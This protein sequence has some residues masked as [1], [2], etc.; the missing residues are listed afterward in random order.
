MKIANIVELLESKAPMNLQESYDN[1]GLL[2]GRPEWVCTGITVSLDATEEVI[3]E[4]VSRN[5]NMVVAHHPIVFSGLKK[6]TGSNYVEKAIIAAIKNDV[7]IYAIHTNLDNLIDGVNGKIADLLKLGN[8]RILIP[9]TGQLKKLVSF[10]PTDHLDKVCNAVFEAGAGSV[11]N[12]SECS[13]QLEGTGTFKAGAGTN[14]FTGEIGVRHR[15]KETRLELV[16]TPD[17]ERRVVQ[18]L[19]SSHPYEEVAYDLYALTNTHS[20]IGSGIIGE[21][22][23]EI[24]VMDFLKQLKEIFKVPVIRHSPVV[25]ESVKCVAICGGA[26]SFLISSAL[27]NNADIY[28]TGDMKY[29]EFFDANNRLVIADIGH[30]ES[31][32]YT[33]DLLC[34]ILAEKFPT[35]A[36]FKTEVKTNPV[37]YYI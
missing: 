37:N 20:G 19:I 30:F 12:Y 22:D 15:E 25:K 24:P 1:A 11:G 36:V 9:K 13:F 27:R 16:Y 33:V 28:I 29:H 18:A 35:F 2:T 6:I 31:E 7:A 26:G 8:R 21:L 10:V 4:A 32:Q 5:H 3:M 23:R 17:I 34:D 14:P